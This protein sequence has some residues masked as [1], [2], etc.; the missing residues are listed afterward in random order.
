MTVASKLTQKHGMGT[1]DGF[2]DYPGGDIDKRSLEMS[3]V[4]VYTTLVAAS[5]QDR[6]NDDTSRIRSF[7]LLLA[8]EI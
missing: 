7:F 2:G 4:G 6:L 8:Q 1:I 3:P 5:D